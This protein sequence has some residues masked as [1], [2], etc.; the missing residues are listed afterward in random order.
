M[1]ADS[2]RVGNPNKSSYIY[3]YRAIDAKIDKKCKY[4]K[5]EKRNKV[6]VLSFFFF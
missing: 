3:G 2:Q 4:A 6:T 1:S 5:G